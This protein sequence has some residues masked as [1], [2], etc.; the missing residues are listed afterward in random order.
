M[1]PLP[2]GSGFEFLNRIVGGS[3]PKTYIPSVEKGVKEALLTGAKGGFQVVDV[4]VILFDGTYHAV[5]SSDFAFQQA[6]MMAIKKALPD[7]KPVLLEPVMEVDI[8]IPEPEVGRVSKDISSRRG[9]VNNYD[10]KGDYAIINADIP[11]GELLD[12]TPALRGLTQGMGFFHMSLKTYEIA[13]EKV[14]SKV[15]G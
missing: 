9:K 13:P 4:R 7:A 5:D 2:R 15:L 8:D 11:M 10:Y 6:G 1:E 12:Y 3:I 14:V